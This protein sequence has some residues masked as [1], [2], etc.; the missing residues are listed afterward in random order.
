MR[1]YKLFLIL[2]VVGVVALVGLQG[3]AQADMICNHTGAT[4]PTTE[5][6]TQ[7][8][9][10]AGTSYQAGGSEFGT[11]C[12]VTYGFPADTECDFAISP[13]QVAAMT[14]SGWTYT[15]QAYDYSVGG[16]AQDPSTQTVAF[17]VLTPSKVFRV[18]L[19]TAGGSGSDLPSASILRR[20]A[21]VRLRPV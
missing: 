21:S 13:T 3:L 15:V 7:Y 5:G 4:N 8:Q 1:C 20:G 10:P 19:G 2:L 16:V 6:F 9:V 12:W 17:D 18:G 11:P 14:A